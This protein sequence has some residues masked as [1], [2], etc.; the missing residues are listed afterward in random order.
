MID[1]K[2]VLTYTATPDMYYDFDA[3]TED[4]ADQAESTFEKALDG[5]I[6][7]GAAFK[8]RYAKVSIATVKNGTVTV[9]TADGKKISNGQLV[10]E[11]TD[12]I[13]KAIPAKHCDLSAWGGDAKGKTGTTVKLTVTK[14][15][16]IRAAFKFRYVKVAIGKTENGSITI[17]T[18]EGKTVKN[19]ASV[20]EGTV[21]ICTA[22]AANN[23]KLGSWTGSFKSTKTSVKV[24][25]NKNM[26]INA[27]FVAKIP[28]QNT[29]GI[30]KNI[31]AVVSGNKVTVVWGKVNKADGY[32]IYAQKCYV[33]F[34]SKSLVKSVKGA[35]ATRVTI[36]RINGKSLAKFDTIK[37]RVK[38]YKLVNGKKK[39]IDNSVMLHIVT[40]SSK[41]TN[42]KKVL[43]PQKSYVLGVK[44]TIKLKPGYTKADA[45]KKVLDGTHGARYLYACTNKNVATVDAKGRI[46]AKAAGK[47]TVYVIAVNGTTQAVQIIVK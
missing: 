43:L 39:Y 30:N 34:G 36:S 33:N 7:V 18:A 38:A 10:Q 42:I 47:C 16:N 24:A 9:T 4:A 37:L 23:C 32:D 20:I 41:Y 17:K 26:K 1:E 14:N 31:H 46:K 3:W 13:C 22:K 27:R 21:L 5:S 40:N 2:T 35:S 11:G 6:T 12:I 19:G 8:A 28:A 15:M 25:A 29:A 45:S 44:Q